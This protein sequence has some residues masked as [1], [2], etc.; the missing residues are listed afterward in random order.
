[1]KAEPWALARGAG[2]LAVSPGIGKAGA[3]L[4]GNDV[5]ARGIWGAATSSAACSRYSMRSCKACIRCAI[6]GVLKVDICGKPFRGF[7]NEVVAELVN[8]V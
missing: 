2:A 7:G 6:F 5:L 3:I 4:V 1:M 8:L